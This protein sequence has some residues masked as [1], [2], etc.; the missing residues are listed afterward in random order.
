MKLLSLHNRPSSAARPPHWSGRCVQCGTRILRD[1]AFVC[2][3]DDGADFCGE[4][5][6]VANET[7]AHPVAA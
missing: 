5:C 4:S 3:V 1:A 7:T 6:A 2:R